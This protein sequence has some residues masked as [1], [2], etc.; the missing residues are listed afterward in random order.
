MNL[1]KE[2]QKKL[3]DIAIEEYK[4]MIKDQPPLELNIDGSPTLDY[5]EHESNEEN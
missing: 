5:F 1:D 3:E 4:K 2:K